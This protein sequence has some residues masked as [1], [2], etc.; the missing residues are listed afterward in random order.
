VK[1]DVDFLYEIGA[2]RQQPRMWH[3]FLGSRGSHVASIT[4]HHYRVV[5]LALII[6]AREGKGDTAKII[7]MALVHDIGESRA[8]DADYLSRQYVE[9][10]ED[11]AIEHMLDKTSL[12]KEFVNLWKAY[13][14]QTSI[15]AKIVKDADNL[16]F[17][18]ELHEQAA[19][20]SHLE[21][22]WRDIRNKVVAKRFYSKAAQELYAEIASTKPSD[23]HIKSPYNRLT[24]GDWKKK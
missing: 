12:Q 7:K 11:K 4:E 9:R 8:G 15:E 23:W 20:G 6:A 2:L 10:H 18:M 16:D 3:R 24:G 21:A 13:E 17:D 19:Q 1:R 5:W 22:D 14:K